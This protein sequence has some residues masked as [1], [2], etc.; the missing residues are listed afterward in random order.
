VGII[1][2]QSIKGTAIVYSGTVIGFVTTSLIFPRVLTSEQ[3]GLIGVLVA[4]AMI[5]ARFAGLGFNT[6]GN[7]LF[8]YF[9]D[10]EKNHNGFLFL[11]LSTTFVGFLLSLVIFF[12]LR[13]YL[14]ETR[15]EDSPLL[16]TYIDYL[17]PLLF[18]IIFYTILDTYYRLLFNA[19]IGTFLKEFVQRLL[20]LIFISVFYFS[21]MSFQSFMA[22]YLSAF[23]IPLVIIIFS[24]VRQRKFLIKPDMQFLKKDFVK[25]MVTVGLFGILV[26]FSGAVVINVDRIMI[27]EFLGLSATGIYATTFY[28]GVLIGIPARPLLKISSTVIAESWKKNDLDNIDVVYTKSCINQ[29]IIG[30]LLFLGIWLN[31]HN[32]FKILPAEYEAG[33]YVILFI[34]LTYLFE[35]M[36]GAS[37]AVIS[38]SK[39]YKYQAYFMIIL[40]V[41]VVVS[42][43][44]L[45][46][47]WG[48]VGA[49]LASLFSKLITYFLRY[50]FIYRKFGLQPY[51][52]RFLLVFFIG[53]ITFLCGFFI[54]EFDNLF[55]D[56]LIRS[57]V[58]AIVFAILIFVFKPSEDVDNILKGLL[59]KIKKS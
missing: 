59:S 20:I 58:I 18:S 7:R 5:F 52:S 3:I 30:L 56:L 9:R 28:F 35:M 36:T 29:L 46:P 47:I 50:I 53:G 10:Q 34:A 38:T 51:N 48:I 8:P 4:Y 24:L 21:A 11:A 40:I 2:E 6:I 44:I 55:I 14:I 54:P 57:S 15:I 13:P 33:K 25:T 19:V 43:I 22:L 41:L 42:N 26:S 45:I 1:K 12:F 17:I 27:E 16:V 23:I 37:T 49:A 39:Y 32:V 31:I